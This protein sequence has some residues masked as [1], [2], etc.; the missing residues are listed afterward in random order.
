MLHHTKSILAILA[1]VAPAAAQQ[2]ASQPQEPRRTP[3]ATSAGVGN[4]LSIQSFPQTGAPMGGAPMQPFVA[5]PPTLS[6]YLNLFRGG[7]GS[8]VT[9]IDYFNFV[10]P[11]TV[12]SGPNTPRGS[13]P[14]SPYG[15][16]SNVTIEPDVILEPDSVLRSAGVPATFMNSGGYFNRLGTIGAGGGLRR[17]VTPRAPTGR[18]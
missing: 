10:R 8:G 16:R 2:S 14:M 13:M 11:F 12:G 3:V 18:R 7:R 4:D 5:P 6:P 17:P 1:L 15:T 9:A